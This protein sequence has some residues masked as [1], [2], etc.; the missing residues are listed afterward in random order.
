MAWKMKRSKPAGGDAEKAENENG[1]TSE[2]DG[3]QE[4]EAV[5]ISAP[6]EQ[7]FGSDVDAENRTVMLLNA[8]EL[9]NRDEPGASVARDAN[10]GSDKPAAYN[11]DQDLDPFAPYKPKSAES[12]DEDDDYSAFTS[13]GSQSGV[14]IDEPV[15]HLTVRM[16]QFSATYEIAKREL[17]IG[18]PDAQI[19]VLPDIAVEWD[20]AVSRNHARILHKEDGDYAED[21]GST[22]GTTINGRKIA[23][24]APELLSNGDIIEI[25]ES[26]QIIY[27]V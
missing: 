27:T 13:L 16:G 18:R 26:T 4:A 1:A 24:N 20:D 15:A 14:G 10:S 11:L 5:E 9:L 2:A 22:N 7:D 25:G 17:T 21:T 8:D 6:S 3:A 12:G 19:D 23:P